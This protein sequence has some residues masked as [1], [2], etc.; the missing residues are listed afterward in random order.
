MV[1][2]RTRAIDMSMSRT[3]NNGK[4][5]S[6]YPAPQG[7]YDPQFE[8]DACGVGFVVDIKGRKSHDIIRMALTAIVNLNHRGAC[9]CEA[10]TG[11]GAG[12]LMQTPDTFLRKVCEPLDIEL[13]PPGQ[14]GVGTIFLPRNR[15]ARKEFEKRFEIVVAEEGQEVLGWRTVPTNNSSLGQ[16]ARASEPFVRQVFVN[17]NPMITDDMA[18]ERKLYVIRKRA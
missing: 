10:N 15:A 7:L 4:P 16:T 17:R 13:P 1:T 11:D 8:H 14:Y 6:G 3:G 9:G 18:F 2:S 5:I 12:I